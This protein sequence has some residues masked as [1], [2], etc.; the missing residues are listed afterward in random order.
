[1]EESVLITGANGLIGYNIALKFL[2]RG[3]QVFLS[4]YYNKNNRIDELCK[5][6]PTQAHKIEA[7][8]RNAEDVKKMMETIETKCSGIDVLINNAG[9]VKDKTFIKM[10]YDEWNDVIQTNLYGTMFIT[11]GVLQKMIDKK[12]GSIVSIASIVGKNGA[13][14]Q[15]NY[16]ASKAALIGFTKS[17]AKEVSKYNIRVNAVT[18]GY[19]ETD[20]TAKIPEDV[21]AKIVASLPAGRMAKPEEMAEAVF[22]LANEKDTTGEV[23]DI[24][25]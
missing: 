1:M 10:T 20:M 19:V 7:D 2:E 11:K 15:T 4:D 12:Y 25:Q 17:L 6:Y 9:I 22:N 21:K 13:Y 14:G 5:K 24:C 16:A 18:P 8:I 23:R 3:D